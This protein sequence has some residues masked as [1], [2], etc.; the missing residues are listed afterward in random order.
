[1]KPR[2]AG[3][4]CSLEA[5][6]LPEEKKEGGFAP[7]IP[8]SSGREDVRFQQPFLFRRLFSSFVDLF[9]KSGR[10]FL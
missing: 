5:E 2:P 8:L 4:A 7:S 6:L 9:G 10:A 3:T 1:M